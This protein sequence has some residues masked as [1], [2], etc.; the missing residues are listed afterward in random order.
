V[1]DLGHILHMSNLNLIN[2]I[3]QVKLFNLSLL[4]SFMLSLLVMSKI[5]SPCVVSG[6]DRVKTRV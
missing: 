1:F 4:I 5:T 3:K 2:L 6:L